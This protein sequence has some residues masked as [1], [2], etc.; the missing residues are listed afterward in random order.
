[1]EC[2]PERSWCLQLAAV[3]AALGIVQHQQQLVLDHLPTLL[4][5]LLLLIRLLNGVEVASL[6]ENAAAVAAGAIA[7]AA[8]AVVAAAAVSAAAVAVAVDAVA[9]AVPLAEDALLCFSSPPE[10]CQLQVSVPV[11][12]QPRELQ[13]YI[14]L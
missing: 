5:S 1:M 8:V 2:E 12:L 9:A 14:F 11:L 4:V 7:A 3:T 13:T 10:V 6:H